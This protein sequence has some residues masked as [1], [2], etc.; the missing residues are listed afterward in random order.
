MSTLFIISLKLIS[1]VL[2]LIAQFKVRFIYRYSIICRGNVV[3]DGIPRIVVHK[4]S[5]IEIGNNVRLNSINRSYHINMYR[6]VKLM[7]DRPNANIFI[8]ENTRIH[9]ACIH[10]YKSIKIGKNC[11][12]AANCQI[13]DGNGHDLS[14]PDVENRINTKGEAKEIIIGDN[15]WIGANSI[16]LPGVK[17][18]NG[19]II[20]AGSV[21][22]KDIPAMVIAGGNPASILKSYA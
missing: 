15:V 9:G 6:G 5:K 7:A 1:Y 19:S 10:A 2:R 21:V 17:I 13:I 20:A 22:F 8:G 16:I 3:F 4:D 11:L 18:G 12:I 14:F